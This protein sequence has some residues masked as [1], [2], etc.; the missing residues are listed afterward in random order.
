M[1][2]AIGRRSRWHEYLSQ[3]NLEIIYVPGKDH[4]V[5]DALSRWA[6]PAGLD[7]D[8][9]FH[10]SAENAHYASQCDAAE[11]LYDN[12]PTSAVLSPFEFVHS[13]ADLARRAGAKPKPAPKPP[14]LFLLFRF[15]LSLFP[16]LLPILLVLYFKK[17]GLMIPIR[18]LAL[19]F[20]D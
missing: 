6:Y 17:I 20:P 18:F 4:K 15:F 13:K 11:N 2:G 5:S 16:S 14:F 12:F 10:G 3:F 9:T 8:A 1:V 7:A 19:L